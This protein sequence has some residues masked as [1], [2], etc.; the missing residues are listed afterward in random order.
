MQ[1]NARQQFTFSDGTVIPKGAK[2]GSPTILT[3]FDPEVYDDPDVFE[4]LRFYNE[5]REKGIAQK[6]LLTTSPSFNIF[7]AGRHPWYV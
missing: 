7:G 6:T 4:P 2:V 3:H 5:A 1:R